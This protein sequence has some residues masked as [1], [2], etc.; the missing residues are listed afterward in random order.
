MIEYF[1]DGGKNLFWPVNGCFACHLLVEIILFSVFRLYITW[2]PY[3]M[4]G[5]SL[6]AMWNYF[7][8]ES[9]RKDLC[10]VD[11]WCR[12][13]VHMELTQCDSWEG[14]WGFKKHIKTIR[15]SFTIHPHLNSKKEQLILAVV[16]LKLVDTQKLADSWRKCDLCLFCLKNVWLNVFLWLTKTYHL[17]ILWL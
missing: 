2:H 14:K 12:D 8:S 4:S 16:Y 5:T 13:R 11:C 6:G 17:Y 3:S 10:G 1:L 9:V 15:M 7:V